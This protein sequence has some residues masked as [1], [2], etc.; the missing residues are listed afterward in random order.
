ML[1][2]LR[3]S[4][5]DIITSVFKT[6]AFFYITDYYLVFTINWKS[7]IQSFAV[8]SCRMSNCRLV[9]SMSLDFF[10]REL[11]YTRTA[12]ARIPLRQLGFLVHE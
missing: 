1:V 9:A 5:S 7:L 6:I 11:L 4:T 3:F 10:A 12:V 2:F 8:F